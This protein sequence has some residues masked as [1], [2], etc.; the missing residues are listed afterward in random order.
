MLQIVEFIRVATV[1]LFV[2]W[3][4]ATPVRSKYSAG[5]LGLWVEHELGR[6]R[7]NFGPKDD[8]CSQ[9]LKVCTAD[10]ERG[11]S[12]DTTDLL[13]LLETLSCGA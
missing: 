6:E 13:P 5:G 12:R 4:V 10:A 11:S 3:N 1:P 9:D 8:A 7:N 2:P